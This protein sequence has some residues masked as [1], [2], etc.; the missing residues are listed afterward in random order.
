MPPL[1]G[2]ALALIAALVLQPGGSGPP[3]Q[4]DEYALKAV[5]LYHFGRYTTWP[6]ARRGDPAFDI[7]VA[8]ADPFGSRLDAAVAGLSISGV[9]LATRRVGRPDDA[10][11]CRILYV[12]DSE[13]A[14]VGDVLEPLSSADVLTVSD[15]PQFVRRGGMVQFVVDRTGHLRFEVN[16]ARV[17]QAGLTMTSDLL[18][19]AN[20]VRGDR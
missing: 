7:C 4:D 14:S 1:S 6:A 17:Q 8:G 3:K 10:R 11:G 2:A 16:L 19:H 20:V 5:Y 15:M 9:R 13:Q 12:S 18:R